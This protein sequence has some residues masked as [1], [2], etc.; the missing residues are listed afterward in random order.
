MWIRFQRVCE[1]AVR[2]PNAAERERSLTV[3][4]LQMCILVVLICLG[5]LVDAI[6]MVVDVVR[7]PSLYLS[8]SVVSEV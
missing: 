7:T 4:K 6:P 3:H 8:I 2:R 5:D 1:V